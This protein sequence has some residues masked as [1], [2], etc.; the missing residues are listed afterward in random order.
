MDRKSPCDTY[1]LQQ[2][3]Y[4][5]ITCV[6]KVV[7]TVFL[8]FLL[9][10]FKETLEEPS[11]RQIQS[12]LLFDAIVAPILS[13]FRPKEY[14]KRN[15]L[16]QFAATQEQANEYCAGEPVVLAGKFSSML[17]TL[18]LGLVYAPIYPAGLLLTALSLFATD[19]A[20]KYC[21]LRTW[22]EVPHVDKNLPYATI[23][24]LHFISLSH[25]LFGCYFMVSG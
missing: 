22:A 14:F 19:C 21:L 13:I 5:R 2:V 12:I 16:T 18:A 8:T 25:L 9:Q 3:T 20:N 11:I 17:K 24:V 7:N 4:F 10:D 23:S 6:V 1:S 15:V